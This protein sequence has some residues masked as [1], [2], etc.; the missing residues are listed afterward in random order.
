MTSKRINDQ[1]KT[2]ALIFRTSD[3]VVEGLTRFAKESRLGASQFT[4]IGALS[5]VILGFFIPEQKTYNRIILREQMEV[6]SLIG[7]ITLKNGEPQ[8]HAHI[9]VGRADATAHGGHL[10]EAIV[11]PTLELVLTESPAHLHRSFDPESGLALI[12]LKK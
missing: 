1:P 6:L 8:L 7:D 9:V 3:K 11:R 5:E 2:F 4:A 10:I 12:D